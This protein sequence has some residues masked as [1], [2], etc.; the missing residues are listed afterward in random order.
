MNLKLYNYGASIQS[1]MS[2]NENHSHECFQVCRSSGPAIVHIESEK[3][4]LNSGSFLIIG[5]QVEHQMGESEWENILVDNECEIAVLIEELLMGKQFTIL[6]SND[7]LERMF[8]APEDYLT[9][10]DEKLRAEVKKAMLIIMKHDHNCDLS[11]VASEV[12][13]SSDRFRKVF[14]EQVGVTFKNYL[15]WQKIKKAFYILQKKPET[16]LVDLAYQS[17]FSDQ[18]HMSKIIKDTFGYNPKNIKKDL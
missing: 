14:K 15:K 11:E 5:K 4:Y 3:I 8:L 1:K 10:V 9:I 17:G 13:L 12:G 18:A 16:K 7:L 6:A 2:D